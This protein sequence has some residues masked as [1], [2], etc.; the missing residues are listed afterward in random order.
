[1]MHCIVQNSNEHPLM[2]QNLKSHDFSC[3]A[4][5]QG[6]LIIRPSFT[7][8]ASESLCRPQKAVF[9]LILL[10]LLFYYYF[11]IFLI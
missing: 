10:L 8:I 4:Y 7:K 2:S 6:K 5:S 11:I 1:M 9:F 3:T